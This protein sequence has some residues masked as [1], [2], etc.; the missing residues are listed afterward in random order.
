MMSYENDGILMDI[1]SINSS[2]NTDGSVNFDSVM[3]IQP[4]PSNESPL[5]HQENNSNGA[6]VL[7][8]S[9]DKDRKRQITN[10]TKQN[11]I[12]SSNIDNQDMIYDL[13]IGTTTRKPVLKRALAPCLFI[14]K[15]FGLYASCYSGRGKLFYRIRQLYMVFI[16]LVLVADFAV[17]I[18]SKII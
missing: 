6:A 12:E 5:Q 10:F 11:K 13:E 18:D 14:M 1:I 9:T 2:V 3:M 16:N 15:L 17:N 8:N 4:S 7:E